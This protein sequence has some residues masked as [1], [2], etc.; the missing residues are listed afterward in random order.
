MGSAVGRTKRLNARIAVRNETRRNWSSFH[1]DGVVP[2]GEAFFAFNSALSRGDTLRFVAEGPDAEEA[3]GEIRGLL[4]KPV[5]RWGALVEFVAGEARPEAGQAKVTGVVGAPQGLE[6]TGYWILN[7]ATKHLRE[8][9]YVVAR[10]GVEEYRPVRWWEHFPTVELHEKGTTDEPT[11]GADGKEITFVCYARPGSGAADE[12]AAVIAETLAG[13][14]PLLSGSP[15][16]RMRAFVRADLEYR[17]VVP[18]KG[19]LHRG[20]TEND[21]PGASTPK[22]YRPPEDLLMLRRDRPGPTRP[23]SFAEV[24]EEKKREYLRNWGLLD[25]YEAMERGPGAPSAGPKPDS[26]QDSYWNRRF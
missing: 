3:I 13:L 16:G 24:V 21:S 1:P 12:G 5:S 23:K 22:A 14:G 11:I 9:L 25:A 7:N 15:F 10:E 26:V 17:K 8:D 2:L 4:E 19:P 6:C 20:I 18:V